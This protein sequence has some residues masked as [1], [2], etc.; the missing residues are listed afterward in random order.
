MAK[1]SREMMNRM[2]YNI[3]RRK[4]TDLP[5]QVIA[6]A[7]GAAPPTNVFT[8]GA[9]GPAP[10]SIT[11]RPMAPI[12]T[13]P[14]SLTA[15]ETAAGV[16]LIDLTSKNAGKAASR[17]KD[18]FNKTKKTLTPNSLGNIISYAAIYY[19]LAKWVGQHKEKKL[20][21]LEQELINKF[22]I[23]PQASDMTNQFMIEALS[24][25][26]AGQEASLYGTP[27]IT[28]T[29]PAGGGFA[30]GPSEEYIGGGQ[31]ELMRALQSM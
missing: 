25:R 29:M 20:L 6:G 3:G 4:A 27:P 12:G 24:R 2:L 7:A 1:T 15:V 10:R 22:N 11:S 30:L 17:V 18:W 14:A 19:M 28:P 31:E 23:T 9:T 5:S 13:D 8:A 26:V 16:K 21:D